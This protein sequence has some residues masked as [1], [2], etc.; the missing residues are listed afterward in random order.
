MSSHVEKYTLIGIL[1]KFLDNRPCPPKKIYWVV[2]Q[3]ETRERSIA[4]FQCLAVGDICWT[5]AV[6]RGGGERLPNKRRYGCA[7]SAKPKPGK[8]SPRNLMP[9]QKVPKN[10]MTGRL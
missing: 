4:V 7:A 8:I 9:G 10:L 3:I 2:Y 6:M 1:S 5:T